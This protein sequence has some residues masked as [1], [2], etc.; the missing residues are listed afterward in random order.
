MT[1]DRAVKIIYL[2]FELSAEQLTPYLPTES[3][4]DHVLSISNHRF[5]QLLN[6]FITFPADMIKKIKSSLF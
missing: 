5:I 3:E 1:F 2:A 6:L 4:P